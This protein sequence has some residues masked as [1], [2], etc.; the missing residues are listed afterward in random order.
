VRSMSEV[1]VLY[2]CVVPECGKA[3]G[4]LQSLR[5]HMKV[6]RRQGYFKTSFVVFRDDW[7]RFNEVCK[8]HNTTT[9]QLLG[10][11]IRAAVKGE[12]MGVIDV[13]SSNPAIVQVHQ[14]FMGKPRSGLKFPVPGEALGSLRGRCPECGS[15]DIYEQK[16]PFGS[17]FRTG[18]CKKCGADWCVN[19]RKSYLL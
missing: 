7:E 6:H 19:P 15:Y 17:E 2:K 9:C 13:G 14:Y 12:E 3:Y 10:A 1:P 11:L 8:A 16:D 4:K 18:R 5:A